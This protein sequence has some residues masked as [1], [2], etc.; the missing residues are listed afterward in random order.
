MTNISATTA[1]E[2]AKVEK[3]LKT[4]PEDVTAQIE[5]AQTSVF[6]LDC[7]IRIAYGS[8]NKI[9]LPSPIEQIMTNENQD[10]AICGDLRF[11]IPKEGKSKIHYALSTMSKK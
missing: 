3:I 2:F 11:I 5:T 10:I 4:L 6:G 8:Q 9:A 1:E 7:T